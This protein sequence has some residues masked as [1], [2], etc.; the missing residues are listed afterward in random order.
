[1]DA[2]PSRGAG[3]ARLDAKKTKRFTLPRLL[4]PRMVRFLRLPALSL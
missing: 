2:L 4:V 3:G 1:M